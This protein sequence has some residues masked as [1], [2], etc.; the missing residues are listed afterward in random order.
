MK[1][2]IEKEINN[3][4]KFLDVA[5]QKV[6]ENFYFNIYRKHTMTGTIIPSDS[7]HPSEHNYA[8]IHY[9]ANRMN[10]YHLNKSNKV[11]EGQ[12]GFREG[13][14]VDWFD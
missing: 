6:T 11:Y 1:F 13:Y 9:V 14:C 7:C 5:V 8:A 2:T 3:T 4:I 12:H 10:T